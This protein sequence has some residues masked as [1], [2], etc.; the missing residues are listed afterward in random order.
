MTQTLL[1]A[2]VGCV[3]CGESRSRPLFKVPPRQLVVCIGCGHEYVHPFPTTVPRCSF[4]PAADDLLATSIDVAFI[5]SVMSRHGVRD[6]RILDVGCGQGRVARGLVDAGWD[7]RRLWLIDS[8]ESELT[9]A[10]RACPGAEGIRHDASEPIPVPECFDCA[11]MVEFLEHVTDPAR[12]LANVL[13]VVRPG[14]LVIARGLPNNHSLEAFVGRE[15]WRMRGFVQHHH[16]FNPDLFRRLVTSLTGARMVEYG[17][18]LQDGLS[19]F[20]VERIARNLGVGP[21]HAPAPCQAGHETGKQHLWVRVREI[22]R[23]T[24]FTHYTHRPLVP[25]GRI[26]AA[27]T[28]EAESIFNQMYLDYRLSPDFSAVLMRG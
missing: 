26:L 24:D 25:V 27:N 4:P 19:F 6:G 28:V 15:R 9:A 17:A 20:T 11:L 22:I 3:V 18:F 10:F 1:T 2:G 7:A 8:S 21:D 5:T 13:D 14:G 23:R 12:V 16:L